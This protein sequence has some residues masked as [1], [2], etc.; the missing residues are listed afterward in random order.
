[1]DPKEHVVFASLSHRRSALAVA[2]S[3]QHASFRKVIAIATLMAVG[4][5]FS[6]ATRARGDIFVTSY[7][8]G[9]I[10]E[11]TTSG[12]TVNASMVSGLSGPGGIAVTQDVPEPTSLTLLFSALLGFGGYLFARRR[13][14][15]G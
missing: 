12:G 7:S 6:P 4:V 1:V 14:A 15:K 10:G 13:R 5:A 11:Y 9:T 2:R 3:P 8:A